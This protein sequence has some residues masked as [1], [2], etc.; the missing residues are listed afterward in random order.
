MNEDKVCKKGL[1]LGTMCGMWMLSEDNL[2][3]CMI[4]LSK[5]KIKILKI[6]KIFSKV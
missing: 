6:Y 2:G 1:G 4:F 3:I 5:Y